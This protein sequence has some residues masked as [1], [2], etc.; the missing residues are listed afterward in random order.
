M[1]RNKAMAFLKEK[2]IKQKDVPLF[3]WCCDKNSLG[4]SNLGEKRLF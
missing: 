4:I 2:I 3:F 1:G